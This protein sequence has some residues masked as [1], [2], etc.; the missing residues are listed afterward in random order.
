MH[1]TSSGQPLAP[2]SQDPIS[3]TDS[4]TPFYT[5]H[6]PHVLALTLQNHAIYPRIHMQVTYRIASMT[7]LRTIRRQSKRHVP[8]R[9][10]TA[11]CR[12]FSRSKMSSNTSSIRRAKA[13]LCCPRDIIMHRPGIE[14]GAGR[15]LESVNPGWQRP[16]LPL[17]HQ[18]LM[19]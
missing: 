4:S 15:H 13:K 19:T 10:I 5:F 17:N 11:R 8:R 2:I 6:T 3:A 12:C 18:C 7:I 16:I 1:L 9:V 14:P